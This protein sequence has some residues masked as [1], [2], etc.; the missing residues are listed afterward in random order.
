[1]CIAKGTY[2]CDKHCVSGW[3]RL[4]QESY[5]QYYR[6]AKTQRMP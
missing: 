6:V 5:S 3:D 1:M 4:G 2:T